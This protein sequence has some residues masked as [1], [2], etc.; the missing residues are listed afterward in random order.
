VLMVFPRNPIGR[1]DLYALREDGLGHLQIFA[2]DGSVVLID[3]ESGAVLPSASFLLAPLGDPGT[4]P[5]VRHR[6]MH[7]EI[8]AVGKS[9]FLHGTPVRIADAFGGSCE[10]TTD[11]VF[12]YGNGP[13]SDVFRFDSDAELFRYLDR[14]CPLI[15]PPRGDRRTAAAAPV[16]EQASATLVSAT[17]RADD[18]KSSRKGGLLDSLL[19]LFSP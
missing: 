16:L 19:R 18:G 2:P 17:A 13:E 5:G 3:G 15:R 4:P 8:H 7:L 11:E 1:S 9:P 6:G 14:R 10:L 12:V